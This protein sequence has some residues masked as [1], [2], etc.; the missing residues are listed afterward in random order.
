MQTL[1]ISNAAD[2]F[3]FNAEQ[4]GGT[5]EGVIRYH[6]F[7]YDKETY[8]KDPSAMQGIQTLKY[9]YALRYLTVWVTIWILCWSF[10]YQP[11]MMMMT[12]MIAKSAVRQEGKGRYLTVSG[13]DGSYPTPQCLSKYFTLFLSWFKKFKHF[14]RS[15]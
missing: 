14:V 7:L 15:F 13:M 1:Y 4:D 2:T 6:P 3:E 10:V 9:L 8:P 5:V 11:P 12:M